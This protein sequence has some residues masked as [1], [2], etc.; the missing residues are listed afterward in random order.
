M[1][2]TKEL[3]NVITGKINLLVK[4]N[5]FQ[6]WLKK[7]TLTK[8]DYLV[9][10]NSVL[11]RNDIKTTKSTK[12]IG[13]KIK[14]SIPLEYDINIISVPRKI[15]E[16]TYISEKSKDIGLIEESG[17]G[18]AITVELSS[19]GRLIFLLIG[20]I[21]TNEVFE[22]LID[23]QLFTK[24]T[25]DPSTIAPLVIN[26]TE[27]CIKDI[28]DAEILWEQFVASCS[29]NSTLP[30]PLPDDFQAKFNSA[31]T[32]LRKNSYV[33]LIIPE[34]AKNPKNGFLD[35][36]IVSLKQNLSEYKNSLNACNG[37]TLDRNEYNN[38]LRISYTFA[39]E[40]VRFLRLFTSI[41]DLKPI[42]LWMTV[43]EQYQF[44]YA[45]QSLP[46]TKLGTKPDLKNYVDAVKGARNKA[47]HNLL[48]FNQTIDVQMGD[49]TIHPTKLRLFSEYTSKGNV[50]EYEDKELIEILTEFT[51]VEEKY[52]SFDFW[53]RN[54]IVM[55]K[56]LYLLESF[57]FTLKVLNS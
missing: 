57:S 26:G 6:E 28:P 45:L 27:I 39:E 48:Q 25:L 12:Y 8:N 7:F 52:V 34:K 41:S 46:W 32:E 37:S 49:I 14:N 5:E 23:H 40:I 44:L 29:T 1:G 36:V 21:E 17:L 10:N 38:I 50:F 54:L 51:R 31:I 4:T 3:E 16:F 18:V 15:S 11:F 13:L 53:K 35:Q 9:I 30:N 33:K 55:E 19:L 2:S 43:Y 24:I 56:T 42:I 20:L 47:F 22:Q